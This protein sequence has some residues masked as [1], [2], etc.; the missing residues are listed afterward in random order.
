MI[1]TIIVE[2]VS[3][4]S[5]FTVMALAFIVAISVSVGYYQFVYLPYITSKPQLPKEITEPKQI[6]E[7]SIIPGSFNQ[8]QVD[9]FVPKIVEVQLGL[10]NKV[11]WTNN[12]QSPHTVTSDNAYNDPWSGVFDSRKHGKT[13]LINPGDKFEFVFTKEG[14]YKYHCEPHPWMRGSIIVTKLKF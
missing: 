3:K 2:E 10:N 11:V 12:D 8:D 6:V 7:V 4:G 5:P 9:N 1:N 13:Q 14:E